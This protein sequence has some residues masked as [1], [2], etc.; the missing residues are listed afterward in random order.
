MPF[1][2]DRDAEIA[3]VGQLLDA[4]EWTFAK[5][6]PDIPHSYTLKR[7]WADGA[8]FTRVVQGI[9]QLGTRRRW[10]TMSNIKLDVNQFYY[11]S[12]IRHPLRP[13]KPCWQ[14][15]APDRYCCGF[16]R[17][18]QRQ[19]FAGARPDL[20]RRHAAITR[21]ANSAVTF[22]SYDLVIREDARHCTTVERDGTMAACPKPWCSRCAR[23]GMALIPP[24]HATS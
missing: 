3:V 19:T 13:V 21:E 17:S 16:H 20:R 4:A 14:R 5:T 8:A 10:R 12:R 6:M 22:S 23:V 7:Q 1:T 2:G 11:W 9:R 24:A 18:L 15:N